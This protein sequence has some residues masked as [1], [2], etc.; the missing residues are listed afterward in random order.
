LGVRT[1][2]EKTTSGTGRVL[3]LRGKGGVPAS[4]GK[5]ERL[6]LLGKG[7]TKL[8][9]LSLKEKEIRGEV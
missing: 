1:S 7:T 4:T 8:R 6:K 9:K 5:G 2:K 3:S